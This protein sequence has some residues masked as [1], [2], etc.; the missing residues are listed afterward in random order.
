M[1][2]FDSLRQI[3]ILSASIQAVN[4][5]RL[6]RDT[7]WLIQ[8]NT[9][10]YFKTHLSPAFKEFKF[11][12]LGQREDGKILKLTDCNKYKSTPTS[13]HEAALCLLLSYLPQS[14]EGTSDSSATQDTVQYMALAMCEH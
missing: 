8:T 3:I 14:G 4:L 5:S 1:Y 2:F 12:E 13:Q 6:L 9:T 10:Q 11:V 7:E